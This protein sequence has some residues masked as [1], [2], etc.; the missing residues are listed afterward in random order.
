MYVS[1]GASLTLL[2]RFTSC[3]VMLLVSNTSS[4]AASCTAF[5]VTCAALQCP[6]KYCNAL[7]LMQVDMRVEQMSNS[8]NCNHKNSL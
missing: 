5:A 8:T 3:T 7:K 6:S 4:A 1:V 2:F